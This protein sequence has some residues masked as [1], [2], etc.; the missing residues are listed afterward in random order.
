VREG[1]DHV[2]HQYT[3][4]VDHRDEVLATLQADGIG[5]D[6]YYPIPNHRLPAY[7]TDDELP[8]TARAAQEVLSLPIHP[9]LTE[10]EVDRVIASVNAAVSHG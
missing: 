4:R 1:S 2:F 7:D 6:V 5:A 10:D 3:L 9:R 8:E